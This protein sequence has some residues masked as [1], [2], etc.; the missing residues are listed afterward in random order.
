MD[1][2]RQLTPK[3]KAQIRKAKDERGVR[4]AIAT[5]K[6]LATGTRARTLDR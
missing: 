6:G 2:M 3:Q 1:F 4:V 5:A